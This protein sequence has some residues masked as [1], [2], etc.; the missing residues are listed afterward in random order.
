MLTCWVG[1]GAGGRP[2]CFPGAVHV[3]RLRYSR[4]LTTRHAW[5][6]C[7]PAHCSHPQVI[8]PQADIDAVLSRACCVLAPS[9]WLEAWGMVVTEALLRG[10]P[11]IISDAGKA[12]VTQAYH[13]T[14][15]KER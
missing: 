4:R 8:A 5:P 11:A 12:E 14:K 3:C 2:S 1:M 15:T 13:L 6:S 7:P 9:L 10:I